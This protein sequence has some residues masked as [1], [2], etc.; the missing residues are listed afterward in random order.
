MKKFAI[1]LLLI[2]TA[3]LSYGQ[4]TTNHN[5]DWL[6]GDWLR[7]NNQP[8]K[9]TT[10]SWERISD[11]EYKGMGITIQNQDTVFYEDMRLSYVGNDMFLI[12]S[13]PDSKDDAIQFKITSQNE[14]SFTA[15]NPN[16]DFPKK[17]EYR[18]S[19]QGIKA[20][21]SGGGPKIDFLFV[22]VED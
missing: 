18:K 6:L 16:N 15:E 5:F 1:T 7:T 3:S 20:I 2:L 19:D 13:T 14:H 17:I 22:K 10:E 11:K 12:V 4:T 9:T 21:I 8:H